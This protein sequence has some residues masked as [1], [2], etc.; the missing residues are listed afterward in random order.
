MYDQNTLLASSLSWKVASNRINL[1]MQ[2]KGL[3][4]TSVNSATSTLKVHGQSIGEIDSTVVKVKR[5]CCEEIMAQ[6]LPALNS[7]RQIPSDYNRGWV[8]V[9]HNVQHTV[10]EVS[11][12]LSHC[13]GIGFTF[14]VAEYTR[15]PQPVASIPPSAQRGSTMSHP[16][17][18]LEKRN[19]WHACQTPVGYVDDMSLAI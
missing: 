18:R 2:L 3:Q 10:A 14:T 4:E 7:T 5:Y 17:V 15:Y 16:N 1:C 6:I 13:L 11:Q 12:W 8:S 19:A 9:Q